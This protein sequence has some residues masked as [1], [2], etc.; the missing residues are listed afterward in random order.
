MSFR[1]SP[2]RSGFTLA[3]VVVAL[4]IFGVAAVVLGQAVSDTLR[5]LTQ[6]NRRDPLS[7]PVYRVRTHALALTTRDLVEEGGELEVPIAKRNKETASVETETIRI[8]WEAEVRPT[9]LL[10]FYLLELT[11]RLESGG[12]GTDQ[13]ETQYMAYRPGWSDSDEM[14]RL[15]EQKEETFK[16]RLSA[17][18]ITEED[19]EEDS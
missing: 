12:M 18:G 9:N 10:N 16:E 6:S 11:I 15:V 17:R 5:A 13:L 8:R 4:I 1:Q 7:Y 3:E 14:E 19:M 2:D